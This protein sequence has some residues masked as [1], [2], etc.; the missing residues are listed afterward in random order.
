[1]AEKLKLGG[2]G[3]SLY[4]ASFWL[5]QSCG[6]FPKPKMSEPKL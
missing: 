1:M 6:W 4:F 3:V 5:D 2:L